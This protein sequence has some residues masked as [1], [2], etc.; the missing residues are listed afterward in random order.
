MLVIFLASLQKIYNLIYYTYA[1]YNMYCKIINSITPGIP[2]IPDVSA[3]IVLKGI[4]K[5]KPAPKMLTINKSNPPRKIFIN[6]LNI[7][8]KGHDN[9]FAIIITAI[10]QPIKIKYCI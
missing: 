8:L 5:P 7:I 1:N 10:I 3:V 6:N 9:I 4:C 2:N